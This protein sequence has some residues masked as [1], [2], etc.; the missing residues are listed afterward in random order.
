MKLQRLEILT[1]NQLSIIHESTIEIL[2][3]RGVKFQSQQALEYLKR[4]GAEVDFSTG[5]TK[6]SRDL[7]QD[8]IKKAP[9]NFVWKAGIPSAILRSVVTTPGQLL[10]MAQL[11]TRSRRNPQAWNNKRRLRPYKDRRLLTPHR[12]RRWVTGRTFRRTSENGI[13]SNLA[14]NAEKH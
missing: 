5:I 1:K 4:A 6:F 7:V 13:R 11:H 12:R 3:N 8:S 9:A 2:E 14:G 10:D